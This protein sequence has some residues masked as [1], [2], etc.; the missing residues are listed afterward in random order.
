MVSMLKVLEVAGEANVR[1]ATRDEVMVM[2]GPFGWF[3]EFV[4]D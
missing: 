3:F 4:G 1:G 2:L